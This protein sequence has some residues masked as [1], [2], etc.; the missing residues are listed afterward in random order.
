[1]KKDF[2]VI[3][4][5][6]GLAGL[7]TAAM[8]GRK[9]KSVVVLEKS[10]QPGGR[11]MTQQEN[12]FRMNLGPH[13]LYKGGEAFRIL[14]DL[15]IRISGQTPSGK[16]GYAIRQGQLYRLPY[17]AS[18]LLSTELISWRAKWE[19]FGFL[20]RL[21]K[22]KTSSIHNQDLRSWLAQEFQNQEVRDFVAMIVRIAT[23]TN[24][25]EGLSAGA[26]LEQLKMAAR[27]NVL[28]L[29][30]GWQ[31]LV[32]GLRDA[33][34]LAGGTIASNTKVVA[35]KPEA[36]GHQVRLSNG[37][38]LEAQH[39]VLAMSP[40]EVSELIGDFHP[41]LSQPSPVKM[42][43][44]TVGLKH[45]PAPDTL[46]AFGY[47]SPLYFSVHSRWAK[48]TDHK[49]AALIHAG[50]YLRPGSDSDLAQD[51]KE[52]EALLDLCQPGWRNQLLAYRYLPNMKVSNAE[53]I[54]TKK[55]LHGRPGV[56]SGIPGLFLCGDWIGDRGMLCDAS[57]ASAEA[58]AQRI[59]GWH[60]SV[61]LRVPDHEEEH[62]RSA[63]SA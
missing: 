18:S 30:A 37:D 11:A 61:P 47:D 56:D 36:G 28:Y 63:R 14:K 32:N 12:G 5:G 42:A 17:N 3:V 13:A 46:L 9:G 6:G 60:E 16:Y 29:D 43:C 49:D 52:L 22:I 58:V 45:L 48:L 54:A 8:L 26:A 21:Q 62:L 2:D 23:Y 39:V 44:L 34:Q 24:D 15:G 50:K 19:L 25:V 53:V 33:T 41:V 55:G 27:E 7:S 10:S 40:G 38:H 51:Q 1:M 31:V 20:S 59:L 4:V 35:L 57:L